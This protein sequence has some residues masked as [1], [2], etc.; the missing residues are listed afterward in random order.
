[1]NRTNLA[2]L[3]VLAL[4]V[5]GCS[6]TPETR[7]AAAYKTLKSVQIAVDAAMRVYGTACATGKVT[8]ERQAEIDGKHI[9]YRESFRL[10]V[11]AAR[12]DVTSPPPLDLQK[13]AND[14]QFLILTL[15]H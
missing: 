11:Q 13:I 14:L 12:G 9:A 3:V 4:I 5:A 1:M 2:A 7:Q 6:A 15:T 8:I 10:A